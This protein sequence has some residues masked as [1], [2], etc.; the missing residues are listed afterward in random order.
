MTTSERA[1]L[2]SIAMTEK[3]IT[4]VGKNGLTDSL[5][6]QLDD[7]LTARELV[8]VTVLRNADDPVAVV[9]QQLAEAL[10][11]Q[12]VQ[13]LGFKITLYRRSNANCIKHLI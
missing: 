4:Q 2:R 3:A 9:A 5:I 1:K 11:A 7:Q 13:T 10:D 8:K 12:V 6:A